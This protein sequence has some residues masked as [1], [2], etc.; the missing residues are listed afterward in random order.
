MTDRIR[1]PDTTFVEF[2][3]KVSATTKTL[4]KKALLAEA[5]DDCKVLLEYA[6]NPQVNYYVTRRTVNV[7]PKHSDFEPPLRKR[8]IVDWFL[9]VA[10]QLSTRQVTGHAAISLAENFFKGCTDGEAKILSKILFREAIGV[11][12]KLVNSVHKNLIPEFDVMLAPNE[13]PEDLEK[14]ITYPKICQPKLDGFRCVTF[15]NEDGSATI[16]TRSGKPVKNPIVVEKISR[17]LRDFR[18]YVFDGEIYRH[19][20]KLK[21]IMSIATTEKLDESTEKGLLK[22]KESQELTLNLW[23]VM[24]AKEWAEQQTVKP[25]KSRYADLQFFMERCP[26]VIQIVDSHHIEDGKRAKEL[27]R[28]FL[29]DGYEGAMLKDP[30]AGYAWKRTTLK[31]NTLVKVKEFE[32]GDFEIIGYEQS[33]TGKRTGKLGCFIISLR[34]HPVGVGSGYDADEVD[35]FWEKRD[36]MIGKTMEVRYFEEIETDGKPSLWHPTF[37]RIREDK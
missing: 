21:K 30:E 8:W 27:N 11:D 16:M 33:T 26:G 25:Y 15:I 31:Q 37:V 7:E 23:D 29:V 35:E 17:A 12:G 1:V 28:Q 5:S 18:G 24:T 22:I 4:E 2:F 14:D 10:D 13:L 6:L 34:G 20:W 36:E 9:D 32:T 19:G 3:N